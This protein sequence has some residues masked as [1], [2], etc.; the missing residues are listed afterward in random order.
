MIGRG[1]TLPLFC[2][3]S[4]NAI[5]G[6][7][8]T[9]SVAQVLGANKN[10]DALFVAMFVAVILPRE[11]S[12]AIRISLVPCLLDK[13]DP[14]PERFLPSYRI[15]ILL[16]SAVLTLTVAAG[17]PLLVRLL[18]PGFD[19]HTSMAA[20]SLIIIMSPCI[21]L[22]LMF[23]SFQGFYHAKRRFFLTEMAEGIWK[24]TAIVGLH[25]WGSRLGVPG[26]A[27][28]ILTASTLQLAVVY[29]PGLKLGACFLPKLPRKIEGRILKPFLKG[30]FVV[31]VS[32]MFRKGEETIDR[33]ILS[34]MGHGAISVFTYSERIAF[35]VPGLLAA[36]MLIPAVP[37]MASMKNS[38]GKMFLYVQRKSVAM[39][40]TGVAVAG[41]IFI[42][43]EDIV[44]FIASGGRFSAQ[45][46]MQ[47][48]ISVKALALG[49]P[50]TFSSWII[51]GMFMIRRD[52][53]L[54]VKC[55]ALGLAVRLG[56][57]LLL[58]RFGPPGI[59]LAKTISLWT[60]SLYLWILLGYEK[61]K[62]PAESGPPGG[63]TKGKP[64]S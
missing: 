40:F 54:I 21:M 16:I 60:V 46:A 30:A 1:K 14:D 56:S 49:I 27:A 55:G 34:F 42:A 32:I 25:L 44:A 8:L 6:L 3:K 17:A 53:T 58:M 5:L 29:V 48:S 23:G 22:H 62:S 13:N 37:E 10:V 45:S 12:R 64:L 36:S 50:A 15:A 57:D 19:P 18:S 39:F 26:Y 31:L 33:I 61:K 59:A 52:L 20:G 11:L 43:A 35:M 47:A 41:A 38:R 63:K 28:G 9:F 24:V 4:A 2:L 51:R 7:G